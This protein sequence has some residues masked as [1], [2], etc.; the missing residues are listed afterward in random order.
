LGF[1]GRGVFSLI[2]DLVLELSESPSFF[3]FSSLVTLGISTGSPL[4][5]SRVKGDE[6]EGFP[7]PEKG[8]FFIDLFPLPKDLSEKSLV[9]FSRLTNI[10]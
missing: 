10:D 1:F 6:F 3:R 5:L 4:V 9:F 2:E 8:G 7:I